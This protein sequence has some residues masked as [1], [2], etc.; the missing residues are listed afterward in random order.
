[1]NVSKE[2]PVLLSCS[3]PSNQFHLGNYL[4]AISNWADMQEHYVS[5]FG[6]VDLHAMTMPYKPSDLRQHTLDCLI[7]YIACGLDPKKCTLFIQSHIPQHVELAWILSCLCPL[8]QLERMTQYKDKSKRVGDSV[9]AGLL[10]YPILQ[11]ADILLYNVD[12]V[13]VGEDQKQHLELTR[14]LAQKFNNNFSKTFKIPEPYIGKTGARIMS[15]QDPSK[16]MS[17]SDLNHASTLFLFE[18]V[19]KI[20]KKITSAVTDSDNTVEL[21]E[22]KPGISNLIHIL[23]AVSGQSVDE[24]K[25][26]FQGR[27]YAPFKNSVADAVITL[28]EPIQKRYD[29]LSKNKDYVLEVVRQ[30]NEKARNQAFKMMRKVYRKV[31]VLDINK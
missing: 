15:L 29:E 22:D 19:E 9:G 28:L 3:Q 27:G 8:G 30:G 2:K 23:S 5:Y 17:K 16:K 4:G 7:Q 18:P 20:R 10:Y 25:G 24:I 1:M 31:G 21:S 6:V 14:D 26:Q 11:A 12:C 13:P